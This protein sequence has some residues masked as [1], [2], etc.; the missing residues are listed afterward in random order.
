MLDPKSKMTKIYVERLDPNS[1]KS[2][3]TDYRTNVD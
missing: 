3:K 1:K 2:K